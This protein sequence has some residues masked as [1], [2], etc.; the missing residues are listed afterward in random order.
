MGAYGNARA[1]ESNADHLAKASDVAMQ[2]Y[3]S[4]RAN[5]STDHRKRLR[6]MAGRV[7]RST[8]TT[9]AD[10]ERFMLTRFP[11]TVGEAKSWMANGG[12]EGSLNLAA[13]VLHV[14]A[15]QSHADA[16]KVLQRWGVS[17]SD[18]AHMSP[19]F[20]E[21]CATRFRT[22]SFAKHIAYSVSADRLLA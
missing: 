10:A 4:L 14:I 18:R 17:V 13:I 7:E 21:D 22:S 1:I 19:K 6:E 11:A 15:A 9:R 8:K 16:G 12:D 5:A 20:V 3:P 2:L